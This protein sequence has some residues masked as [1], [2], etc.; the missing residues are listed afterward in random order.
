MRV[1]MYSVDKKLSESSKFFGLSP[2]VPT[3]KAAVDDYACITCIYRYFIFQSYLTSEKFF[4]DTTR[5]TT[6]EDRLSENLLFS[7]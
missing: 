5:V 6:T 7:R 4:R 3:G 1:I 2:Y